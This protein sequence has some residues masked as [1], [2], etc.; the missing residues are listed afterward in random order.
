MAKSFRNL[1]SQVTSFENLWEAYH[2]ARRGKRY[3]EPAAWFDLRVEENMLR[4][5]EELITRTYQ[6]GGYHHFRIRE[7]KPRLISAAPFRD[8]V[9]H[10][11]LVNVLEPIYEARFSASSYACRVGKGTHAAVERAHLAVRHFRWMLKG[12]VMKFFP[13]V[14][15]AIMKAVLFRKI[16]DAEVQWL[17]GLILDSG[18]GVLAAEAPPL[19]FAGDDLL[20][21]AERPKGLPIGNLTSQ[22]FA[23]VL[24]N[25][26]D[27]F[28]HAKVQ[29][30]DY[31]RY[32]D[33]FILFDNDR[34]KLDVARKLVAEKLTELRLRM[35][36]DKT[37]VRPCG[38]GVRFLGFRLLPQTRRVDSGAVNRFRRRM[39]RYRALRQQGRLPVGRLTQSVQS[40]LAH[41]RFANT[42]GLVREVFSDVRC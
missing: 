39:R 29:P 41:V 9:V 36:T 24:L 35:H 32:A 23:N 6:P 20:A 22:F 30:S 25:E 40:W 31:V 12:D 16:T 38:Q 11:A 19:W 26:M 14:D 1:Y 37:S 5:R 28:V 10:H 7:P 15:H 21:P 4:L 2:K 34:S 3:K 17:I 42:R 8:R 18:A 27:Q 13:S 33:D